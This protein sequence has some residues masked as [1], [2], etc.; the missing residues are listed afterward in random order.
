MPVPPAAAELMARLVRTL[1]EIRALLVALDEG[2]RARAAYGTTG[3]S[4]AEVVIHLTAV[5]ADIWAPRLRQLATEP[6]PTW[7]WTEPDMD[8]WSAPSPLVAADEFAAGR[9]ALLELAGGLP[10]EAW[11]RTGTHDVLGELDVAGLLREA[12]VHDEEHLAALRTLAGEGDH[13]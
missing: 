10:A 2:P 3:W 9:R 7:A 6:N 1:G 4:P 8:G 5:D 13:A 12:L 11:G